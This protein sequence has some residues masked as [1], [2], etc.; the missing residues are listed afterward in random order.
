MAPAI[1]A[2]L[3]RQKSLFDL[4]KTKSRLDLEKEKEQSRIIDKAIKLEQ[5]RLEK[6][7]KVLLLGRLAAMILRTATGT[8]L[9]D[10]R[11]RRLGEV[12]HHQ[13]DENY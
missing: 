1:L 5:K 10:F 9:F 6:E 7:I 12:D 11:G 8:H 3:V 13:A 4:D 2:R